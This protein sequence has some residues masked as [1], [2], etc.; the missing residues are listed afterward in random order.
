MSNE[1]TSNLFHALCTDGSPAEL[2]R[3]VLKYAAATKDNTLL[4]HLA[5]LG[6]LDPEVEVALSKRGEAEVLMAWACRPGRSTEDLVARFSSEKRATLLA[7]LAART[8]LPA[9]VY[10]ELAKHSSASVATALLVNVNAPLEARK[11]AAERAVTTVRDSYSASYNVRS[12][13]ADLPQEV[14]DHAIM[15]AKSP[16][17]IVGL[18]GVIS[19]DAVGNAA[20][21]VIELLKSD[22]AGWNVR[23]ALDT[24]WN[25]LDINGRKELQTRLLSLN[26]TTVFTN[27]AQQI[28]ND[29]ASRS[30]SDPIQDA[31]EALGV[32]T[33]PDTIRAL[34]KQISSA[35]Y[36]SR[37]EALAA[38]A[39]NPNTPFE[40]LVDDVRWFDE[41]VAEALTKRSDFT[42]ESAKLF[43]DAR[44]GLDI[45]ET[46]AVV[47]DAE[48]MLRY[49]CADSVHLPYWVDNT[50]VIQSKPVLALELYP[51]SKVFDHAAVAK[52]ARNLVMERLGDDDK[53]WETFN[54]LASEWSSG[55][56]GLLDAVDQL[57]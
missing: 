17:Q 9:D 36:H 14:R 33:D 2:Q 48:E 21:R 27:N 52:L 50:K 18:V 16:A 20:E 35:S 22:V 15:F 34:Y 6:N 30:L 49:A 24:V 28:I 3:R 57:I 40:I 39:G 4:V 45:F 29:F 42:I 7:E 19:P 31:I 51:I 53:R 43:L 11:K 8:D 25:A 47:V 26:D 54:G 23:T 55:L 12:M 38:A 56:T 1:S 44:V 41:T 5:G 32:E 10:T 37:K 46:F 13:F